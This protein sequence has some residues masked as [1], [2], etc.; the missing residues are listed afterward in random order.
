MGVVCGRGRWAHGLH[1]P[2]K[3]AA[4]TERRMA[5]TRRADWSVWPYAGPHADEFAPWRPRRNTAVRRVRPCCG[6]RGARSARSL[7]ARRSSVDRALTPPAFAAH[8]PGDRAARL[9][10][11]ARSRRCRTGATAAPARAE[12]RTGAGRM[13]V[14]RHPAR[15]PRKGPW[16]DRCRR[17]HA[18]R[19]ASTTDTETD[20][21]PGQKPILWITRPGESC[22][23]EVKMRS[24]LRTLRQQ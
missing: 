18:S 16:W 14:P 19:I 2:H 17:E 7:P 10:A 9:R 20:R 8:P 12:H 3:R 13:L 22:G 6:I 23:G 4:R 11:S 1:P 15:S 21:N 24:S 5:T